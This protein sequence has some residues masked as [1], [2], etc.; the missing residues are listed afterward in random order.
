MI[1]AS[2]RHRQKGDES[3]HTNVVQTH[4]HT[5]SNSKSNSNNSNNSNDMKRHPIPKP[6]MHR[7]NS[8]LEGIIEASGRPFFHTIMSDSDANANTNTNDSNANANDK[9]SNSSNSNNNN[10]N[11]LTNAKNLIWKHQLHSSPSSSPSASASKGSSA[12]ASSSSSYAN[13]SVNVTNAGTGLG[14]D[15]NANAN[16]DTTTSRDRDTT[17]SDPDRGIDITDVEKNA[18]L[19]VVA[20]KHEYEHEHKYEHEREHDH[21]HKEASLFPTE[22]YL[23]HESERR[24][25]GIS[26]IGIGIGSEK[27]MILSP[28][29]MAERMKASFARGHSNSSSNSNSN[30]HTHTQSHGSDGVGV[31]I[32]VGI[33]LD[34]EKSLAIGSG[35]GSRAGKIE[36]QVIPVNVNEG[37]IG[38]TDSDIVGTG[39]GVGVNGSDDNNGDDKHDGDGDSYEQHS[40]S[41]SIGTQ[42]DDEIVMLAKCVGGPGNDRSNIHMNGNG[43][44]KEKKKKNMMT[45]M[46]MD[47]GKKRFRVR[48]RRRRNGDEHENEDEHEEANNANDARETNATTSTN[49]KTITNANA[50]VNAADKKRKEKKKVKAKAKAHPTRERIRERIPEPKNTIKVNKKSKKQESDFHPLLLLKTIREHNG[51][52]WCSA[53]SKDGKYFATGGKDGLVILWELAPVLKGNVNVN[54]NRNGNISGNGN[55]NGGD[56]L[57]RGTVGLFEKIGGWMGNGNADANGSANGNG[58]SN[59]NGYSSK[60]ERDEDETKKNAASAGART[61]SSAIA[62]IGSGSVRGIGI[63]IGIGIGNRSRAN[64]GTSIGAASAAVDT[65]T[66]ALGT[67]MTIINPLPLRKYKSH[68]KDVVDLSWSNTGYLISASLDKTVRLWHPSRHVCLSIFKHPDYVTSVS[69]HPNQDKYFCSGGFDK[70]VRIWNIPNGRVAEWAQA[71]DVITSLTYVPDAKAIAAGLFNGKVYFYSLLDKYENV[72]ANVTV[73]ATGTTNTTEEVSNTNNR[74]NLKLSYLTHITTKQKG[75]KHG[76]KV[77]GLTFLRN[78]SD[79]K[80]ADVHNQAPM[81]IG[82]GGNGGNSPKIEKRKQHNKQ[83]DLEQQLH[84]RESKTERG[85]R[86][87]QGSVQTI[88]KSFRRSNLTFNKRKRKKVKE[89]LL[90]TTNDSRL[91]L[92]GLKDYCTVRKYKGHS[93]T[94]LQIQAHFS[95]SGEFIISGSELRGSVAIWNTATK[96]NPLNVNVTGLNMYDKVKAHEWFE[97]TSST[98]DPAI[99]TDASFAP[100]A[101]VKEALLGSGLFPTLYT[102]SLNRVNHDF[103]SSVVVACDYEGSMRVFLRKSCLTLVSQCAGAGGR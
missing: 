4:K 41:N 14:L 84:L 37:N 57:K 101:T 93:N 51:P 19:T 16:S 102:E 8:A 47:G 35:S 71:P 46:M 52:I 87:I 97:A 20:D 82:K 69:F 43:K 48:R 10:N 77:T 60:E 18:T 86:R 53:F 3:P 42:T 5:T 13:S 74:D 59:G 63:G 21:E 61:G 34:D 67:E 38:I 45:M 55:G 11:L 90:I 39:V 79:D 64:T 50:N 2:L 92:V 54:V 12:V 25:S 22:D 24:G 30:S 73:T 7:S 17:C 75:K 68:E 91:S 27:L 9:N 80:V 40:M 103:S 23:K 78:L 28:K 58:N 70:K 6:S 31:G 76:K 88:A 83:K 85:K 36:Q 96:R 89:Q 62:A 99:V 81:I 26:G 33:G 49:A 56:G 66:D 32:G 95:E 98:A 94:S 72:D 65:N 29:K 44:K 100:S 1:E 15:A